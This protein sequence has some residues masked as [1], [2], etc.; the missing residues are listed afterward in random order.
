[1]VGK[2]MHGVFYEVLKQMIPWACG[3][4]NRASGQSP[5]TSL[6]MYRNGR[7]ICVQTKKSY[8]ESKR[9]DEICPLKNAEMYFH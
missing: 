5:T 1:M 3:Q 4:C 7:G 6:D 9:P 2:D 8:L